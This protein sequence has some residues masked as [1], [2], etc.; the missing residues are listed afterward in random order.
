[1]RVF[2][3]IA[4]LEDKRNQK[5][6]QRKLA[7]GT[8]EISQIDNRSPR[9][10]RPNPL[11]GGDWTPLVMGW[12]GVGLE[13]TD[14]LPRLTEQPAI[15]TGFDKSFLGSGMQRGMEGFWPASGEAAA[16]FT[17]VAIKNPARSGTQTVHS[18]SVHCFFPSIPS[19]HIMT[20]IASAR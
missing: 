7:C 10:A 9:R 17:F 8:S 4:Q 6:I 5:F 19:I 3:I 16:Q 13:V 20:L 14:Q 1:M 2:Y 18:Q 12:W 11:I 15:T